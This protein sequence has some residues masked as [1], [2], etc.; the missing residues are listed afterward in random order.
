MTVKTSNFD[1]KKEREFAHLDKFLKILA[2]SRITINYSS[3]AETAYYVPATNSITLPNFILKDKDLFVRF[4]TH[5]V[6][7]ALYTP[8]DFYIAHN[9]S[10]SGPR[11]ITIGHKNITLNS[12]MFACINIVEDIR[13]ERKIRCAFP[14]L[15]QAYKK[16]APALAKASPIW[17]DMMNKPKSEFDKLTIADKINLKTK[18]KEYISHDLSSIEYA[19]LKYVSRV[20]TFVD[21]LKKAYYLYCLNKAQIQ[22]MQNQ[23]GQ[24][25]Q[26]GQLTKEDLQDALEQAE[27]IFGDM[28]LDD[29]EKSLSEMAD[30][31]DFDKNNAL[32]HSDLD[33]ETNQNAGDSSDEQSKDKSNKSDQSSNSEAKN[34]ADIADALDKL[35]QATKQDADNAQSTPKTTD[36]AN[37]YENKN[38]SNGADLQIGKTDNVKKAVGR[39]SWITHIRNKSSSTLTI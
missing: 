18:F 20:D 33:D 17:A 1:P 15:V 27:K 11:T 22:T 23:P 38:T 35:S 5:E 36:D 4:G 16:S 7:H 24:S 12:G 8:R 32:N 31:T 9:K 26:P 25:G 39:H 29:F 37:M 28:D 21:V 34:K 6:A 13:I 3:D 10:G 2:A 14:G 30:M 19:V